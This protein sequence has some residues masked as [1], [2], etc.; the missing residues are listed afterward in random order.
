MVTGRVLYKFHQRPL[1]KEY[2]GKEGFP[3]QPSHVLR[4]ILFTYH[5]MYAPLHSS[6][7]SGQLV[8]LAAKLVTDY[9]GIVSCDVAT[10]LYSM[11]PLSRFLP[12]ALISRHEEVLYRDEVIQ[13]YVP[14]IFSE[15]S[16]RQ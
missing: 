5:V 7:V 16:L 6:T 11:L 14:N 3:A 10:R 1:R 4:T 15:I 12:Q 2:E 9:P 8:R 13:M